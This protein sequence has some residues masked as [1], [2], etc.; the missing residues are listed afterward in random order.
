MLATIVLLVVTNH[1][2][3]KYYWTASFVGLFAAYILIKDKKEFNAVIVRGIGNE[4][5]AVLTL[6][7]VFAGVFGKALSVGGL[8]Q[9]VLWAATKLGISVHFFPA[10]I[11]VIS[12]LLSTCMGTANGTVTTMTP[13]FMPTA[14]ALGCNPCLV[15]GA[16]VGGSYFGDNLAPISDTTIVSASRRISTFLPA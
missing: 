1:K 13:V 11:F 3:T 10:A 2:S 7:F 6:C 14:V 16:I 15:M 8:A 5:F 12:A 4:M 9:S